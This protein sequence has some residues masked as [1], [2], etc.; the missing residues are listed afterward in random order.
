MKKFLLVVL[1]YLL[2]CSI[3]IIIAFIFG[4]TNNIILGIMGFIAGLLTPFKLIDKIC[5]Q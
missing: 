5:N 4:I 3:C 1:Y 2:A